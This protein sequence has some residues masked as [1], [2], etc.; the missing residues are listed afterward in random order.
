MMKDDKVDLSS[1][2]P[3]V[4]E[5]RWDRLV[6]SIAHR[7]WSANKRRLTV[8][9]QLVTWA[10]PALAVAACLA[11]VPW[12]ASLLQ[13]DESQQTVASQQDPAYVLAR[14]AAEGEQPP[15]SEILQVLGD[16][17]ADR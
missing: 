15:P 4:D 5:Q 10:R 7:A 8:P 11:L 12:G 17:H 16:S 3:T 9:L 14:W 13:D 6:G 2:D 1:L